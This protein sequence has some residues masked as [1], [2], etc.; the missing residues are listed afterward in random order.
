MQVSLSGRSMPNRAGQGDNRYSGY[1][2]TIDNL[3]A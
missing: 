3:V 1:S 2:P